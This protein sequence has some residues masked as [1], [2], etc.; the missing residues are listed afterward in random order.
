MHLT[1]TEKLTDNLLETWP[2]VKSEPDG[3][4]E[5]SVTSVWS[6]DACESE[7]PESVNMPSTKVPEWLSPSRCLPSPAFR[8]MVEQMDSFQSRC[9]GDAVIT[10]CQAACFHFYQTN[11]LWRTRYSDSGEGLFEVE[12]FNCLRSPDTYQDFGLP[13]WLAKIRHALSARLNKPDSVTSDSIYDWPG[14][15]AD[16]SSFLMIPS[17]ISP[18]GHIDIGQYEEGLLNAIRLCRHLQAWDSFGRLKGLWND[19]HQWND[20]KDA[21]PSQPL[22]FNKWMQPEDWPPKWNQLTF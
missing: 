2:T 9:L 15:Y 4:C 5:K 10:N 3:F 6:I 18:W 16:G 7:T 13:V 17:I 8:S 11:A 14:Y 12:G 1:A 20:R 19:L 21:N 22:S